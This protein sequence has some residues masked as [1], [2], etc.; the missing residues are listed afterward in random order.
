MPAWIGLAK[1][2]A[3]GAGDAK[4]MGPRRT[5]ITTPVHRSVMMD[6]FWTSAMVALQKEVR[7]E[8]PR[9][10]MAMTATI[11]R[12]TLAATERP[13]IDG[14]KTQE[15]AI[16]AVGEQLPPTTTFADPRRNP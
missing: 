3:V 5:G 11:V 16:S 4:R 7:S 12:Q 10:P 8:E 14:I 9:T 15:A 6:P 1:C 2:G 13:D